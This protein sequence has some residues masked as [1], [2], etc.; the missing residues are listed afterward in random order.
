MRN[1]DFI[2]LSKSDKINIT[3][4]LL[5]LLL[6]LPFTANALVFEVAYTGNQKLDDGIKLAISKW[7]NLLLDPKNIKIKIE[8]AALD[9]SAIAQARPVYIDASYTDTRNALLLD[10][11]T[12]FDKKMTEKL[13][14]KNQ[15]SRLINGTSESV[16]LGSKYT[17]KSMS[18]IAL[19]R[20]NAKALNIVD[21]S[22]DEIDGLIVID[23]KKIERITN[24]AI[25]L[26]SIIFHEIAHIL[27][28]VSGINILDYY[29]FFNESK[30]PQE[31]FEKYT[32]L[33]DFTRCSTESAK[34]DADLDWTTGN[35]EKHFSIEKG[36]PSY[37][38]T[39]DA[40]SKGTYLGDGFEA[41]HWRNSSGLGFMMPSTDQKTSIGALDIIA[42]DVIGWDPFLINT[43]AKQMPSCLKPESE[44]IFLYGVCMSVLEKSLINIR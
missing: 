17:Q 34:E 13:S 31:N 22:S 23:N 7:Q 30:S 6:L 3:M 11:K 27:G 29:A 44:H 28:F 15:Y 33:L 39:N 2:R 9:G 4:L 19:T 1:Y 5:L 37:S 25:N 35:A 21:A 32:T 18:H 41:E 8:L 40:W 38:R 43:Y 36:C 14:D 24:K 16:I 26:E 10:A 42:F 20:A 12:I